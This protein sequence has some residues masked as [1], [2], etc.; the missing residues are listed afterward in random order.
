MFVEVQRSSEG[1]VAIGRVEIAF[2]LCPK[3]VTMFCQTR[4]VG[5]FKEFAPQLSTY[6]FAEW[7]FQ[8]STRHARLA[9]RFLE[10]ASQLGSGSCP[11]AVRR[12]SSVSC[13]FLYSAF[14]LPESCSIM[15]TSGPCSLRYPPQRL[16]DFLSASTPLQYGSYHNGM[17][18]ISNCS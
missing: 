5:S 1:P 8:E 4:G 2:D 17:R 14:A 18:R 11:K 12:N 3:S 16:P 10:A 13:M 9:Q 6:S 7:M 15:D